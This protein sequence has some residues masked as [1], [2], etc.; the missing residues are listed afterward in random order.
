MKITE[1]LL[2]QLKY[3]FIFLFIVLILSL[4]LCVLIY[5]IRQK[6]YDIE[7]VLYVTR[8]LDIDKKNQRSQYNKMLNRIITLNSF[9]YDSKYKKAMNRDERIKYINLNYDYATTLNF[10]LYDIPIIHQL[11]TSFNPYAEGMFNEFGMGQFKWGTA[12]LCKQILKYMPDNYRRLLNF[13]IKRKEDL[14]DIWITLKCTYI[15]LWWERRNFEGREDWYISIYHWGGFVARKWLNGFGDFPL[16]FVINGKNYNPIKYYIRWAELRDSYESGLLEPSKPIK[17]KWEN[18]Y[19]K[20]CSEEINFRNM[21]R[22]IKQ[23]QKE[24]KKERELKIEYEKQIEIIKNKENELNEVLKKNS[25]I[26]NKN[27][28][29]KQ[30]NIL[31]TE[32][33]K[34]LK[35]WFISN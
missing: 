8:I 29:K 19:K 26:A 15:L 18:Y 30:Y 1:T 21:K 23:L 2:K 31:I 3:K 12:L 6:K 11:E 22:K 27:G 25:N 9:Q 17:E 24:L 16:K 7:D 13:D 10:G 32:I 33:R 20:L 34:Y 28:W 5:G 14:K 35:K 4:I